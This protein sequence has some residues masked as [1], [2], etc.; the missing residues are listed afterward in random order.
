ML[1]LNFLISFLR[2]SS[3]FSLPSFKVTHVRK[4]IIRHNSVC[5]VPRNFETI[6]ILAWN[7]NFLS[8]E[9]VRFIQFLVLEKKN[10]FTLKP[11]KLFHMYLCFCK[12]I[13]SCNCKNKLSFTNKILCIMNPE[14]WILVNAIRSLYNSTA[15]IIPMY[16]DL[17]GSLEKHFPLLIS[18][19]L[20]HKLFISQYNM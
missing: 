6:K 12:I 11:G 4:R 9:I 14:L 17:H 2:P 5:K 1:I 15:F 18:V 8:T 16:Y 19:H 13:H 10:L 3:N 7:D 20:Y